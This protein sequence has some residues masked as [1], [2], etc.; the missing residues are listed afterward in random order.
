MNRTSAQTQQETSQ[1]EGL[2]PILSWLK[3]LLDDV[4]AR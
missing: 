4:I 2:A 3:G 1:E